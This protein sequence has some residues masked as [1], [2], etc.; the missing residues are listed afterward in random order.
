MNPNSAHQ[1]WSRWTATVSVP[2]HSAHA[3]PGFERQMRL[4]TARW[5]R[6][7]F[8]SATELRIDMSVVQGASVFLIE[9]RTE[10]APASDREFRHA[11]MGEIAA[12]LGTALRRYGRADVRVDV[13]VEAG[14]AG[15]GKP[16]A[17]LILGPSVA[18]MPRGMLL[19]L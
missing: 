5:Y 8:G 17:Q 11:R 18:L 10:G 7:R 6:S 14:D 4:A 3:Q 1:L 9:C 2:F 19:G 12:F 15:D 13:K 16:R